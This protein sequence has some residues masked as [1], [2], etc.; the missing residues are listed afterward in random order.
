MKAFRDTVTHVSLKGNSYELAETYNSIMH[1]I[2][3]HVDPLK[4]K[5]LHIRPNTAWY[6]SEI[7]KAKVIRRR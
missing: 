3:N 4:P 2:L 5:I 6:T 7:Q 1:H